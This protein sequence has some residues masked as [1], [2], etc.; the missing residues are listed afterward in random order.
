LEIEFTLR[1]TDRE[2]TTIRNKPSKPEIPGSNPGRRTPPLNTQINIRVAY[3][4]YIYVER[5]QLAQ[6]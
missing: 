4:N 2:P 5:V 6:L 3:H 1:K